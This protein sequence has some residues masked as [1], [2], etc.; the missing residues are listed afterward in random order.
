MNLFNELTSI[1]PSKKCLEFLANRILSDNYRGLQLSQHNRYD[2]NII[3]TLLLEMY[4]IVGRN[5]M[6]IRTTDLSKRPSNT[7]EELVY[8][9]YINNVVSKI[10]RGTQDSVRKNFFVDI[11]RMGFIEKYD[12]NNILIN[13]YEKKCVFSVC[14]SKKGLEFVNSL[15]DIFQRNLLYTKGIDELTNGIANEILDVVSINNKLSIHEFMFF[16]SFI[17]CAYENNGYVFSKSELTEYML[18]YRKLSYHQR[19]AV[20]SIIEKYCNPDNYN[21]NKKIKRDFHN[22]KNE[23][24]QIFNLMNQTIFYEKR[25]QELFIKLGSTALFEDETKLKRSLSQK[26]EYFKNHNVSKQIGFELHHV[27]PL[28]SAKNRTE[29]QALDVWE[30]MIY[31]DGYTHSKISHTKNKN[32]ELHFVNDNVILKDSSKTIADI[33]C[34]NKTNILYDISKK[35]IMKKYNNL[36]NNLL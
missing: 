30:N 12:K 11:N 26:Q 19:K 4:N 33:L 31:I 17:G 16:I 13:P 2:V 3:S 7:P 27:I 6:R 9:Q 14:L 18:E 24:Q 23:T 8:A 1:D 35:D 28:L 32:T 10:G 36:I 21:G 25:K 5:K 22:W 20:V 15:K 34:E 29:F